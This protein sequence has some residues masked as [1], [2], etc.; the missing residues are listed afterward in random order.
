MHFDRIQLLSFKDETTNSGI[1]TYY[2]RLDPHRVASSLALSVGTALRVYQLSFQI[3]GEDEVHALNIILEHDFGW[4]ATHFGAR[5]FC[6]PLTLYYKI[7]AVYH[8]LSEWS[9]YLPV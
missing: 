3:P 9:M 2:T 4:I 5:N 1:I 7:L 6:I 8:H